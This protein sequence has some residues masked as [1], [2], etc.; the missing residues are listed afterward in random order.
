[1]KRLECSL[2]RTMSRSVCMGTE[3]ALGFVL[4]LR[5]GLAAGQVRASTLSRIQVHH[6]AGPDRHL[7]NPVPAWAGSIMTLPGKG[8]ARVAE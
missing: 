7:L 8:C 1:M 6:I 3:R 4:P 5:P 2:R